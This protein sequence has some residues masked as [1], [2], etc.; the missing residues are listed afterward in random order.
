MVGREGAGL[1]QR[2]FGAT[3]QPSC[4]ALPYVT[5]ADVKRPKKPLRLGPRSSTRGRPLSIQ[6]SSPFSHPLPSHTLVLLLPTGSSQPTINTTPTQILSSPERKE[7]INKNI[8]TD[9]PG[10]LTLIP[11]L[12]RS[13]LTQLHLHLV[14]QVPVSRV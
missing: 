4:L 12:C 9:E 3:R 13:K 14:D 5:Q 6:S 10:S 8:F 7:K 1:G 11:A 2:P